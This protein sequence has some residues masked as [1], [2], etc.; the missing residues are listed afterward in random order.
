MFKPQDFVDNLELSEKENC[1]DSLGEYGED[2]EDPS[3]FILT[4]SEKSLLELDFANAELLDFADL[5]HWDT[6]KILLSDKEIE[7]HKKDFAAVT[8]FVVLLYCND[9]YVTSAQ[10][11]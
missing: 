8:T 7:I 5:S 10:G 9:Q 11:D 2:L 6:L 3:V 4:I 1:W